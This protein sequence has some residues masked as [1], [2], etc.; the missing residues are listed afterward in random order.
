M[1]RVIL[2]VCIAAAGGRAAAAVNVSVDV[3]LDRRLVHPEIYGMNF[4][5]AAQVTAL[6]LPLRRWGGNSV[7]R[8]NWQGIEHNSASDWFYINYGPSQTDDADSFVSQI[9]S[10]GGQALVTIPTIGWTPIDSGETRHWGFSVTKYG[11]QLN[12]EFSASGGQSWANPD[13]G[14]GTC[15]TAQNTKINPNTGQRYCQG[16]K[17]VGND[18]TDTSVAAS[19][20]FEAAWI[21]HLQTLF[22]TA[23]AGGVRYYALDNEPMLWNSTH[24]DVHPAAPTFA[25]I[26]GKAQSYGSAIKAQDPAAQVLG[27]VTWGY[28]DLFGSAADNCVDGSDRAAHGGMPFVAWYLQQV[29]A[30]PLAGGRRLV[31]YLDLHYYPQGSNIALSNSEDS[32]GSNGTFERR[33]RSLK[34]LYDP[35]WV[36]ESWISDLGDTDANHYSK[37]GLLPRVRAWIDQYCPGTG[38]AITEYNW[39]GVDHDWE[40]TTSDQGVSA[41]LAQ[42]EALAI[43]GREGVALATRWVAPK[44]GTAVET[45]FRLFL[46]YDG[47]GSRVVGYATRAVS[48]NVDSVGA[49]A[50]DLP[51]RRTMV[52]LFNKTSSAQTVNLS[53]AQHYSGNWTVFR[54]TGNG[55]GFGVSAITAAASGSLANQTALSLANVPARSAN[56]LV[57]PPPSDSDILYVDG[58]D[59][60]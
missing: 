18:A 21:A 33:L 9:R 4:G 7:T 15:D 31:D 34:E 42:A 58:F 40:P 39:G 22:G 36:S 2:A 14:D 19:P 60:P 35:A 57:L 5:T 29:C 10:A 28:C 8:Y 17:I 53:F 44:V 1:K 3:N 16:G 25:E 48:A 47:S 12:T 45:A 13:A 26:W 52:L 6:K 51:R 37:P 20:A 24:R 50:V 27:P 41:A 43:F 49:Y 30:N 11:P 32:N 46:D 55:G 23:A 54:F 56:L 38:I 59:P